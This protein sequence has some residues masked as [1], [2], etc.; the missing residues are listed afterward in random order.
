M[1]LKSDMYIKMIAVS[2]GM[3]SNPFCVV[4]R[5]YGW[6]ILG[7]DKKDQRNKSISE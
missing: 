3:V 7:H 2:Y 5:D 1:H 4:E 6:K